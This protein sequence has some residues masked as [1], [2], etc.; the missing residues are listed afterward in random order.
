MNENG[1]LSVGGYIMS[2]GSGITFF[3]AEK[4]KKRTVDPEFYI[5]RKYPLKIKGKSDI[6][7]WRKPEFI[8]SRMT[9]RTVWRNSLKRKKK[10]L[11]S[12]LVISGR[13]KENI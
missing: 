3:H 6:F 7:R 13:K 10:Q 2:E 1:F 8:A 5:Q 4:K 12:I 11:K 9:Q